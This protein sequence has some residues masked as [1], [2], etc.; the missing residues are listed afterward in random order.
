MLFFILISIGILLFFLGFFLRKRICRKICEMPNSEKY[1]LLNELS[2]PF[3]FCYLPEKDIF[4][5]RMDALQR[6]FGYTTLYDEAALSFN[7][8]FDREP[9][10]FNY[11]GKTWLIEFW[12]GQYGINTGAEIGIYHADGIVPP[13]LR[14]QTSFEAAAPEEMLS[15][16]LSLSA[17]ERYLFTLCHPHWW[18]AGFSMGMYTP[19]EMLTMDASISFPDEEMCRSFCRALNGLGY[20]TREIS[21]YCDTVQFCFSSPKTEPPLLANPWYKNM[22]LWRTKWLTRLFLSATRPF[23]QTADRLLFLYFALPF[24][25]HRTVCVRRFPRQ[26]RKPHHL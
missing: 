8:I 13:I 23:C 22:A 12:K 10:F 25:F 3:G 7:M 21:I 2:E 1:R 26:K 14:H 18:L 19:P 5:T 9:V 15:F 17:N 11:Q 4:S 20:K 16:R 24:A 6:E